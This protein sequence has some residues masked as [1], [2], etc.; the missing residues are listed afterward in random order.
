MT[1]TQTLTDSHEQFR[2]LRRDLHQHPELQFKEHRT[3][4][5]VARQL[6]SFGYTVTTGIAE[7]GVIATLIVGQ[8]ARAIAIRADMDALPITETTNLPYASSTQGVMHACGHDGHTT[9]LL[10]AAKAIAE[11]K[12]FSGT[13][14]LVFQPAEEDISGAKRMVDE[15]VFERFPVDGIFAFH[16]LPGLPVGQVVVKPGP[17]TARADIVAVTVRGTGGHGALPHLT[18]DPIVAA[19]SIVMA[20]QTAVSRNS[21]PNDVAVVTVGAFNG[22]ILG[23]IIPDEV[24]LIIGVRTVTPQGH[25]RMSTRIPQIIRDQAR[26]FGCEADV[27]YGDGIAYPAGFND[28]AL[29]TS[30]RELALSLGQSA[31]DVDLASPML[32]SEDFAFMQEKVKGCYF[33]I[34]N[35][36]SR[37]LH[38]PGYDF[39]DELLL[40]GAEF[41]TRLVE[42]ELAAG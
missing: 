30:V 19:S 15:G 10:A 37:N 7:T 27:L 3:S 39:N 25:A 33:G 35:G 2:N 38:D 23:T 32:F 28:A 40:K 41:W 1:I 24:K 17:I 18:A 34:G 22:G 8:G 20:L 9:T 42:K 31:K 13:L 26:S 21:D 36:N 4:E 5:I 29:V 12:N 6:A 14:H 16:N 11:R